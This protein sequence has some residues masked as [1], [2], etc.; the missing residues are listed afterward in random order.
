MQRKIINFQL[1]GGPGTGKSTTAAGL[2]YLMKQADYQVEYIQ[3]YAKELTYSKDFTKLSDQ[4]LILGE[5]HHRMRRLEGHVDYIIHD[6]PFVMGLTY[7]QED[8]HLPK[9]IYEDLITTMFDSYNNVN[10][11]LERDTETHK[12]QEYG[13]SQN[14]EEAIA[15]DKEIL[16]MLDDKNI[17]YTKIPMDDAVSTI[18]G[19]LESLT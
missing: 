15:K 7:L 18:F 17:V 14:L 10:I 11:F 13:R 1:F 16:K 9:H 19:M 8:P 3:E 2:F 4:L 6:S 12:Y 5:Q